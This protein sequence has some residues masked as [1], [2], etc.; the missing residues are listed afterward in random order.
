MRTIFR[1]LLIAGIIALPV[2]WAL[3]RTCAAP[4]GPPPGTTGAR[5]VVP[6]LEALLPDLPKELLEGP[7][8]EAHRAFND[9]RFD[10]A[11]TVSMATAGDR[12]ASPAIR[13]VA[14]LIAAEAAYAQGQYEAAAERAAAAL[15]EANGLTPPEP[16]IAGSAEFVL[17]IAKSPRTDALSASEA[18]AFSSFAIKYADL[19]VGNHAANV[20][21]RYLQTQP[22]PP[23]VKDLDTLSTTAPKTA[24]GYTALVGLAGYYEGANQR[25]IEVYQRAQQLYPDTE[26]GR[27]APGA[28]ERLRAHGTTPAAGTGVSASSPAATPVSAANAAAGAAAAIGPCKCGCNA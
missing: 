6:H 5:P 2:S 14:G 25:A 12:A 10:D 9:R 17:L 27:R 26:L 21:V 23:V 18:G 8:T 16:R 1:G 13:A 24:A 4:G 11:A 28:I 3:F 7:L 20:A 22:Q 19:G 15:E